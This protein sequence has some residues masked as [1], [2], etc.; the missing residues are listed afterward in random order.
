[1]VTEAK[2]ALS[3][4]WR[5]SAAIIGAM[6]LTITDSHFVLAMADLGPKKF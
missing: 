6:Q 3:N 5:S 2:F 1:V 4:S